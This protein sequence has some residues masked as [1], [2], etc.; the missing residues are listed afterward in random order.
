MK[1][2]GAFY[3]WTMTEVKS[4]LDIK[5]SDEKTIKFSDIFCYHFNIKESGNLKKYQEELSHG[6]LTGKNVLIVYDGIEKTAAEFHLTIEETKNYLT[7]A[8][9][10]LYK[11]RSIGETTTS[12]GR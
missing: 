3:V 8:C 1:K 6:E 5:I 12:L 7:E 9:S 4:L 11:A 2:E 10:I